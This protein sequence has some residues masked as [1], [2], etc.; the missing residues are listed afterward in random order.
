MEGD[1]NMLF[2]YQVLSAIVWFA[3]TMYAVASFKVDHMRNEKQTG[4]KKFE[5]WLRMRNYKTYFM[6]LTYPVKAVLGIIAHVDG[7]FGVVLGIG[8]FIFA[9]K[10]YKKYKFGIVPLEK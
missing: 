9:L 2:A 8:W 6:G 4:S 3:I 5:F 7:L 1:W 10:V